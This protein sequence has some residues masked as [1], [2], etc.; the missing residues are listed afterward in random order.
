MMISETDR[1]MARLS[2]SGDINMPIE[3]KRKI[4]D[5][6]P[7]GNMVVLLKRLIKNHKKKKSS[8]S[9]DSYARSGSA[10]HHRIVAT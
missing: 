1:K 5:K 3:Y 7:K 6:G 8:V 10:K 4:D 2:N 9:K